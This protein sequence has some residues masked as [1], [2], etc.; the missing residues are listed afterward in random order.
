MS[1]VAADWTAIAAM[2]E[3]H[4]ERI[5]GRS[6]ILGVRGCAAGARLNELLASQELGLLET[7]ENCDFGADTA[8]LRKFSRET[9]AAAGAGT[10]ARARDV[11]VTS[12]SGNGMVFQDLHPSKEAGR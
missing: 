10:P 12:K 8:L 9:A 4:A 6:E 3:C 2:L 1:A 7:Q 11:D 5:G